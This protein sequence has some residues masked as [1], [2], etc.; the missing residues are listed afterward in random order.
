MELTRRYRA[1]AAV[2]VTLAVLSATFAQPQLLYG[3]AAVGAFLGYRQIRYLATV[4][5]IENSLVVEQTITNQHVDRGGEAIVS[6]DARLSRPAS[7]DISV[8]A[9]PPL[10]ADVPSTERRSIRLE[11]DE[12]TAET[13][14]SVTFPVVG[15]GTF[16][17]P[18]VTVEDPFDLFRSTFHRGPEP[19]VHVEPRVPRNVHVGEGG[20]QVAAA[21][22]GHRSDRHG[23]GIDP[24]ELRQYVPGDSVSSI[25]WK[26]TARMRYP[27]VREY[28]VETDR[29]TVMFVDHR[30]PL[31]AG[32][33][34]RTKL[35]YLR[36]AALAIAESA[37]TLSDPLGVAGIGPEGTTAWYPPGT[38]AA[39][40][41]DV[42]SALYGF[43]PAEADGSNPNG[44]ESDA[45]VS[46]SRRKATLLAGEQS[47]YGTR[48]RPFLDETSGYVQRMASDPLFETV[49]THLSQLSS[50]SW[51]FVFT[52]DTDRSKLRETVKLAAQEGSGVVVFITP[53]V[54][55]EANGLT[56]LDAAYEEYVSFEEFRRELARIDG[57]SALEVG[58][59]DRIE[60]VLAAGRNRR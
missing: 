4:R 54:L 53:S 8:E 30:A 24:A 42:Q 40:Y 20:D 38:D 9:T 15:R 22:G 12:T 36:E 29:Q 26:A 33:D 49:R 46:T 3:T 5:E 31:G 23:T 13:T 59:G 32:S 17:S 43:E 57:V 50:A 16:D 14:F 7:A 35:D 55:F 51:L 10:F 37:R 44:R 25:D 19:T 21:F 58:P 52:D 48:V 34:G 28:E 18:T 45:N 2:G 47:A 39:A 1:L 60:A 6:L 41:D 11:P 27:H 56:D